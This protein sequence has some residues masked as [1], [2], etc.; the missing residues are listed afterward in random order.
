MPKSELTQLRAQQTRRV[1][2]EIGPLIDAWEAIPNDV[3]SQLEEEALDFCH[4]MRRI[5]LAIDGGDEH[6]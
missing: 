3:K 1:M 4:Y 2:K 5:Y 6:A